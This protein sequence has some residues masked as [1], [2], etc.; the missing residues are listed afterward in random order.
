[1]KDRL[2]NRARWSFGLI[3]VGI[4]AGFTIGL[5]IGFKII[6]PHIGSM[7]GFISVMT[8][9]CYFTGLTALLRLKG[10]VVWKGVLLAVFLIGMD[11]AARRLYPLGQLVTWGFLGGLPLYLATRP[12]A[13]DTP[14]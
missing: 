11:I 2:R 9:V 12:D 3:G 14:Q 10:F 6:S 13:P 4:Q 1:M 7:T 5:L 8:L